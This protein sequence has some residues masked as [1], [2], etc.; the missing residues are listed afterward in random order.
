[1]GYIEAQS[2]HRG[3]F[4]IRPL[5]VD[6]VGGGEEQSLLFQLLK[7]LP[8]LVDLTVGIAQAVTHTLGAGLR[9]VVVQFNRTQHVIG[10]LVQHMDG[11]AVHIQR[12]RAPQCR[13]GMYHG[14]ISFV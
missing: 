12:D 1:M 10:H 5:R 11:A 14:K 3:V 8:H 2:L 7:L 13:K 4:H 9:Q 6:V